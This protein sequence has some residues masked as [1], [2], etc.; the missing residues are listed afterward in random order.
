[1][2]SLMNIWWLVWEEY[3]YQGQHSMLKSSFYLSEN[4]EYF[5]FSKVNF[6]PVLTR[7]RETPSNSGLLNGAYSLEREQQ[8]DIIEF[9]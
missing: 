7:K 3:S 5:L 6:C 4:F 1:M 2:L 8:R 9:H